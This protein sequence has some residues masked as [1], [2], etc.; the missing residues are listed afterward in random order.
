M[1]QHVG[2]SA[3]PQL[4]V[5]A[6]DQDPSQPQHG[7]AAGRILTCGSSLEGLGCLSRH[8]LCFSSK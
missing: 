3:T 4:P 2:T 8:L 7:H 5:R 6:G 1:L